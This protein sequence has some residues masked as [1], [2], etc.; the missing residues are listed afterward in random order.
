[1]INRIMIIVFAL[2]AIV[3]VTPVTVQ[4][5]DTAK[6]HVVSDRLLGE[7]MQRNML[8]GHPFTHEEIEDFHRFM[9]EARAEVRQTPSIDVGFYDSP[10]PATDRTIPLGGRIPLI[11]VHG[12]GSDKISDGSLHRPLN[13]LERWIDYLAAFN[14]DPAFHN[15]YKVYRF[16]YDSR[17]SILENGFNLVSVIDNIHTYAGWESEN[18][19]GLEYVVLAHSMGGLVTRTALNIKFT[20][21]V[22]AGVK[23][24][25][26]VI[27][28]ITLGTPHRGS[29]LAVPAWAYDSVLR[30]SGISE[31]EYD[32]SYVMHWAWDPYLGQFDLAWDNYDAAVPLNDIVTYASTFVA[33]MN[34]VG[35][36]LDQHIE[37]LVSPFTGLLNAV[38]GFTGNLYLYSATNPPHG[39]LSSIFDLVF[40]YTF[41]LLNEHHLLGFSSSKQAQIIAGDI[42][43]GDLKPYGDNDGLVPAV[44]ALFDGKT[45]AFTQTFD[46]SDHLSLLDSS[47]IVNAVRAKLIDIAV[48]D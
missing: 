7:L 40:Y 22:D 28:P 38:D 34:E 5:Q 16:V 20:Q 15:E 21:G 36:G 42:G 24:G 4:A 14:A 19:D 10:G 8:A 23:L 43:G 35:G 25:A 18:L 46:Q 39:N 45:A 17:L 9:T 29:P 41:G 27:S 33:K 3:F 44:S 37:T 6:P 12:S 26:R 2:L 31:L 1:M 11:L 48:D 30:D 32:F 13:D 47:S